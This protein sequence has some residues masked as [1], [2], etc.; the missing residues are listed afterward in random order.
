MGNVSDS[1]INWKG[2]LFYVLL[3][4]AVALVVMFF[5]WQ[6]F[7]NLI[8]NIKDSIVAWI[9]GLGLPKIDLAS[10]FSWVQANPLAT[11]IFGFLGTTAVGYII[12]NWQTNKILDDSTQKLADAQAVKSNLERQVEGLTSTLTDKTSE[13]EMYANDT[14]AET[15]QLRIQELTHSLSTQKSGYE[16]QISGLN[17]TIQELKETS[18]T[19]QKIDELLLKIKQVP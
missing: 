19:P 9:S 13:L 5:V 3:I 11:T 2:I 10:I 7:H 1:K 6:P 17:K 16:S 14:T 4:V 18:V 12:K 15:L 8:I